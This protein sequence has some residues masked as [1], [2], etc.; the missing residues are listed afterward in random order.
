MLGALSGLFPL[1]NNERRRRYADCRTVVK[2]KI[3][4]AKSKYSQNE[5]V[6]SKCSVR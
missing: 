5:L 2:P 4:V 3:N 1:G 6:S